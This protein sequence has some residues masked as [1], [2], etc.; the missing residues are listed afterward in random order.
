MQVCV[1]S[2]IFS[3]DTIKML[4]CGGGNTKEMPQKDKKFGMGHI[5]FDI[6]VTIL[7]TLEVGVVVEVGLG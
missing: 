7:T 4:C 3:S 6:K 1:H 2:G 5:L